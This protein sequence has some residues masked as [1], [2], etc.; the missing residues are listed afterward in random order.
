MRFGILVT[1][2]DLFWFFEG[3]K[4]VFLQMLMAR[5]KRHVP[6]GA[7]GDILSENNF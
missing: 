3:R 4:A 7:E 2:T 5:A 1:E 6:K